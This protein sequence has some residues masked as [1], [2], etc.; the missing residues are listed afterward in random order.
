MNAVGHVSSSETDENS[1]SGSDAGSM[2]GRRRRKVAAAAPAKTPLEPVKEKKKSKVKYFKG[3]QVM[4][5]T[6]TYEKTPTKH[7]MSDRDSS[8]ERPQPVPEQRVSHQ[9]FS[10]VPVPN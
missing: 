3:L 10:R 7:D 9:R 8:L 5:D 6:E 4:S 1:A 2:K